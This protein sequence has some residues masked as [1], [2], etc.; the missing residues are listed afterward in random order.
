M[1]TSR[2]HAT[3]GVVTL[4]F[5][6]LSGELLAFVRESNADNLLKNYATRAH[7]PLDGMLLG[8][9]A[10]RRFHT[11]RYADIRVHPEL[12]P[13]ITVRQEAREAGVT[14]H[15]PALVADGEPLALSAEVTV[16]LPEGDCR[17]VWTLTLDNRTSC[18]VDDVAFPAIDGA[19]LGESWQDDVLVYP[20]FAGC[21]VDNPTEQLASEPELIHW[22]WQEYI[23]CYNIG[24]ETGKKDERG[25]YVRRLNY[26]GEAS[27]MWMDLYDPGEGTG[28]YIACR[29]AAMTMKSLRM[30]SFGRGDPGC[31]L[32]ILHRPALCEGTWTSAPCV[33]AFHEGDWH[34]AADDYRA[35]VA[36]L[37]RPSH[38]RPAWFETSPGL[39]AHYDFQYQ[40]GGIVHRYA[41]IPE[42]MRMAQEMG[43][44]H[45]LLSGWNQDGF[46]F[47]FPH[48]T[49]NPN[50]GTE[51]ELRDAVAACRRMGGH[52]SFYINA[53]LC[54]TGFAD[55][56][57]RIAEGAVMQRDGTLWVEKY[58]ADN[59]SFASM[60]IGDRHW[61][62]FVADT[63]RY[64][65]HDIGADSMYLDQ[66]AM[67]TSVKCYHPEHEHAGNPCAW[68]QGYERLLDA[69][70]PD[71]APEGMA[72]LYEG[73]NDAFGPRAS[74]QLVS[75]LHCP[76]RG[77][78]PQVYK[79]TFPD[80]I[81]MDMMN[82]RRR[83]AMRPEHI[84][85]HSTELLHNAFTMGAYLWCYDLEEDN[86]WRGD[87]E[88]MARLTGILALRRA[89]LERYG[90][91]RFTDTVGLREIPQGCQVRRFAIGDG[92]LLACASETGLHGAV[93]ARWEGRGK[94]RCEVMTQ[95]SPMPAAYS[96]L[97]REM[98]GAVWAEVPLPQDETAV[99]ALREGE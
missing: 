16:S 6:A 68:N 9:G 20:H 60:C 8:D 57:Q 55:Q 49:P 73:C 50:L 13:T 4:D 80:Q 95:K 15:Y 32:A 92:L 59:L 90:Q 76:F 58:G 84:A 63:V 77:R 22:K 61:R 42:L 88:A 19:W 53:R 67:G 44:N 45:L 46:D 34:W 26:S 97:L 11:P 23:Y 47:G 2:L 79:Y 71:Y 21:R 65:T 62:D 85:R 35:W 83:S 94:P 74:G 52:V 28:L 69:M 64:L 48:Y 51:Q 82:P 96:C 18:E 78:M 27:M 98:D 40:G 70:E 1:Y 12:R 56:Q 33:L 3:N 66:F 29:D 72:L 86:C 5:D 39:M 87:D 31:G 25:A 38:P 75:E 30:E 10:P 43:I 41:D 24:Q 7:S 93:L 37:G 89:W 99:I 36:S 17:T 91:G 54:N 14:L 81:L